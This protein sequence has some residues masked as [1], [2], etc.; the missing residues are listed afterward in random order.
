MFFHYFLCENALFIELIL[1]IAFF[2]YL[3]VF[4]Y[5]SSRT[6]LKK[7]KVCMH[8]CMYYYYIDLIYVYTVQRNSRYS[9]APLRRS[10]DSDCFAAAYTHNLKTYYVITTIEKSEKFVVGGGKTVVF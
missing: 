5:I 2:Y 8:V 4:Y 10:F 6:A 9:V 7:D 1:L 3:T